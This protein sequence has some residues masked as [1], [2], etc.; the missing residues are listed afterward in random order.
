MDTQTVTKLWDY[1]RIVKRTTLF[2]TGEFIAVSKKSYAIAVSKKSYIH[3]F[4][5]MAGL[6][7]LIVTLGMQRKKQNI[8]SDILQPKNLIYSYNSNFS[9]TRCFLSEEGWSANNSKSFTASRNHPTLDVLLS[10]FF[11]LIS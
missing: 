9:I 10:E 5:C 11:Q 6:V 7:V 3:V 8:W 2:A 1:F 4:R